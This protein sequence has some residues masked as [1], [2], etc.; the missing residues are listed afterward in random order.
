VREGVFVAGEIRSFRDLVAWQKAIE[1]CQSV[2]EVSRSLPDDERFG[3][4][5]QARRAAISVPS[6]IAEGYGRRSKRDYLRF[7]NMALGSLCELE[8]Q[9]I[10]SVRLGFASG[11]DVAPSVAL[12][13]DVDRLLSGLIRAVRS[14]AVCQPE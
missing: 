7:L 4:V 2:Y 13:R 12:V 9:L 11:D 1:L 5:A 3:L 8:T 14:S 10:L 6:N